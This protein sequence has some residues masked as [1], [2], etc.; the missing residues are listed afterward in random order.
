MDVRE[1]Q[2]AKAVYAIPPATAKAFKRTGSAIS[3]RTGVRQPYVASL[4]GHVVG[5]R[6]KLAVGEQPR[7]HSGAKGTEKNTKRSPTPFH[8]GTGPFCSPAGT[9]ERRA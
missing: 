9:P 3:D 2:A 1:N 7:P 4:A 8:Q 5:P 6:I